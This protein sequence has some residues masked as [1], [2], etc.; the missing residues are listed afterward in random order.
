[1]AGAK[2]IRGEGVGSC[3]QRPKISTAAMRTMA[4]RATSLPKSIFLDCAFVQL[5]R[6][7]LLAD[8][9]KRAIYLL[10]QKL[11]NYPC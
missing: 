8:W 3:R 9:R 7:P 6:T 1:M 2:T 4:L 11:N 10:E 5:R